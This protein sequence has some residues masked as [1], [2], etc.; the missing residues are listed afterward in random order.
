M[1]ICVTRLTGV[2]LREL[3]MA[4][5]DFHCAYLHSEQVTL[6]GTGQF[7][8]WCAYVKQTFQGLIT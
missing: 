8:M 1:E 7:I 3:D 6:A 5:Y 4:R 2:I